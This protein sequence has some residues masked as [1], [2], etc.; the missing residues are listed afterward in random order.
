MR[1]LDKTQIRTFRGIFMSKLTSL[2]FTQKGPIIAF[3]DSAVSEFNKLAVLTIQHRAA[4]RR[5]D[6]CGRISLKGTYRN[7]KRKFFCPSC[8]D[9]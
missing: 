6:G 4:A 9:A 2:S 1:T 3:F 8:S 5:C 7:G